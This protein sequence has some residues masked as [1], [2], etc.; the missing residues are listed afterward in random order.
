MEW[1]K[2][3]AA[4]FNRQLGFNKRLEFVTVYDEE[5]LNQWELYVAIGGGVGFG[6]TPD[7]EIA[8]VFNNTGTKLC[9]REAVDF[10]ISKGG[11]KVFC[12]DGFLRK[13]YKHFGFKV[14]KQARWNEALAPP[15]WDY[16]KYKT[17]SVIWLE[18]PR[19][20]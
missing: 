11:Y 14:V 18:L 9:G 13:Y 6:L 7:G 5:T 12:F 20:G 17:P 19:E 8:N 4:E 15:K 10:A 3:E 16:A 2:V 1:K